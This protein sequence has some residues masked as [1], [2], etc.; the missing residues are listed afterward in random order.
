MSHVVMVS[1]D[2]RGV[3]SG[4][5]LGI[6][7]AVFGPSDAKTLGKKV[8]LGL[9]DSVGAKALDAISFF[10]LSMRNRNHSKEVFPGN[11]LGLLLF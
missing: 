5:D 10:G 9:V 8:L 4:A 11:R 2:L 7:C 6:F 1:E 3:C